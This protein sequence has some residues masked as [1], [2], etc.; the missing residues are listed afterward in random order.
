MQ[1]DNADVDDEPLSM[2]VHENPMK[3]YGARLAVS[4]VYMIQRILRKSTQGSQ[5]PKRTANQA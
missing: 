1:D 2:D 3:V 4:R 5:Y